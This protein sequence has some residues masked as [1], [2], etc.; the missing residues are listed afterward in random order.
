MSTAEQTTPRVSV[1]ETL[2]DGRERVLVRDLS[3]AEAC[4]FVLPPQTWAV[5]YR[6]EGG[7]R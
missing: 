3:P 6:H 4:A 7:Q 1:I 2:P 5:A